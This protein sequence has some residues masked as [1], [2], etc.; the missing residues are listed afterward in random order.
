[1]VHPVP[2]GSPRV[3]RG[4]RWCA[5]GQPLGRPVCHR[6]RR[7]RDAGRRAGQAGRAGRAGQ[8]I[9]GDPGNRG[10]PGPA[11]PRLLTPHE[12]RPCH[13]AVPQAAGPDAPRAPP[14]LWEPPAP[15]ALHPAV[16]TSQEPHP[17]DIAV[18][19]ASGRAHHG[20][21]PAPRQT[22]HAKSRTHVGRIQAGARAYTGPGGGPDPCQ[23]GGGPDPC[24]GW[25]RAGS[26]P[27]VA[28]GGAGGWGWRVGGREGWAG[29]RE[30]WAGG[31]EGVTPWRCGAWR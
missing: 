31:R 17:C 16:L 20:H 15:R 10:R 4:R 8:V 27:G 2:A 11:A 5:T 9:G 19:Q 3:R 6:L 12:P 30:G 1:M 23:A 13:I 28:A 14:T 24:R 21:H 7:L 26:V 29:G 18:G 25:R 22:A